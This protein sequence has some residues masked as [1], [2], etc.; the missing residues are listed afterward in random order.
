MKKPT[1]LIIL[2][3]FGLSDETEGNAIKAARTP[4][5]DWL[6]SHAPRSYL[7]ASGRSVGLMD[8][9]MGDSM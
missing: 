2:D 7:S 3:G 1:A 6:D 5:V 8:G 4:T 9:Q